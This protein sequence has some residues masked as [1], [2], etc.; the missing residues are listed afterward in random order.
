MPFVF[1]A[2]GQEH[3]LPKNSYLFAA[4]RE[5]NNN[6]RVW[7]SP[8]EFN[9]SRFEGE[10]F[11]SYRKNLAGD[12]FTPFSDGQ[13]MCPAARVIVPTIF[14]AV[15][16]EFFHH[17]DLRLIDKKIEDFD[18]PVTAPAARWHED[19]RTQL[20]EKELMEV[21]RYSI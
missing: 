14:N 11:A 16:G 4:V 8:R 7:E 3:S 21:K 2:E 10:A 13:R 1:Q 9:P 19:F 20:V 18:I 15:I 6:P 5:G 12:Y 17:H